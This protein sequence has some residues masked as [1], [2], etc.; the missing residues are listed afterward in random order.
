MAQKLTGMLNLSKI[1]KGLIFDTK[2]GDKAIFVDICPNKN[3]TD[4]YGN[5]HYIRLYNK[6]TK[7]SI[8]LGNFKPETFGQG[9]SQ[10]PQQAQPIQQGEDDLPW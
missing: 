4:E 7:E 1:P 6:A 10:A 3:G 9:Q 8:Y 5:T 2:K